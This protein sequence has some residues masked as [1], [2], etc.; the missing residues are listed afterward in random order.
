MMSRLIVSCRNYINAHES[1]YYYN[2]MNLNSYMHNIDKNKIIQSC[3]GAIKIHDYL[4]NK[5]KGL[6]AF[7][8]YISLRYIQLYRTAS[9]QGLEHCHATTRPRPR[10][11]G[12]A[13]PDRPRCPTKRPWPPGMPLPSVECDTLPG[14]HGS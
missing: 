12:K 9:R 4:C 11:C 13:M 5:K 1:L 3:I 8:Y 6:S 14:R 10:Q 2:V 7:Y